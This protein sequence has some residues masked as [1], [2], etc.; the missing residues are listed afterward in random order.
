MV[1]KMRLRG[2]AYIRVD[3]QRRLCTDYGI[4]DN[5]SARYMCGDTGPQRRATAHR[6][7]WIRPT[8]KCVLHFT[9]GHRPHP[10]ALNAEIAHVICDRAS[11]PARHAPD[12]GMALL[13][14][15]SVRP[16]TSTSSDFRG[17]K[18]RETSV[19]REEAANVAARNLDSVEAPAPM[20][21]DPTISPFY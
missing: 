12:K 11:A 16:R 8:R 17:A 21:N 14:R 6:H 10:G 13:R 18:A 1:R 3:L 20:R 7:I 15:D 5:G 19:V 9:E 2:D 4:Y